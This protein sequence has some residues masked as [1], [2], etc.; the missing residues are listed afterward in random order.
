[1]DKQLSMINFLTYH[2]IDILLVQEHNIRDLNVICKELNELYHILINLSIAHNGGTAIFIDKRLNCYIRNC[3]MSA[4][5][6]I[7]SVNLDFYGKPLHIINVYAPSGGR[8]SDR[9]SFFKDDL[10]YYFRN[11]LD[12]TILG[13]DFNCITSPRDSSSNSTHVCKVLLENLRALYLKDVWFVENRNRPIEYTY[14]RNNYGSRID[15]MYIKNLNN[16]VNNVRVC[17]VNLS[18]HSCVQMSLDLPNVPKVGKFYWKLNASLLDNSEIKDSFKEEWDRLTF[19]INRYD[20]I[21]DWWEFCA[22]KNIKTF[23]INKGKIENQKKYG[24]LKY[25]EYSLNRLYN[26][27]NITNKIDYDRVKS[28]KARIT[29]I[30]TEI[31]EGV[32][33]R[34]RVDEQLKGEI[35]STFLIKK[36]AQIKKKQYLTEIMSEPDIVDN[37]DE[38]IIL[39]NRDSI[40]L[41]I[42]KYYEKLYD[43]EPFDESQQKYFVDLINNKLNEIDRDTLSCEITEAEILNAIK[44][45]NANK[46]PGIDGIPAEF[47]CKFWE[48]IKV[49]LTKIIKNIIH[50][51][52]LGSSQRKAIIT[53]LPKGGDLKFMKSWRPISL[54]CCDVKIVSKILANRIRP[55]MSDIISNNQYCVNGRTIT[56]CNNDLRDVLYYYGETKS[57]GAIINLDWEKAFDRVNW[58]FLIRIMKKM[59]FPESI[60]NWVLVLHT[61]IQSVCMVNGN[62]TMPFDIKRGVRQGCPMSMLFYV[63]FQEPL[64]KAI[65]KCKTIIPP[66]LPSKQVKNLGY[67]DDTSIIVKSDEGFVSA[68]NLLDKFQRASNSKLNLRKTKV[69]GFGE[70]ENRVNWPIK[71][72]KVEMEYFTTLGIT[73]SCRYDVAVDKT[74]QMILNKIKNR[75]PLIRDRYFTLYQKSVIV[76]CLLSSKIWYASHVYPLPL[77]FS[78]LINKELFGYIWKYNY[79]PIKRDVLC[80]PKIN[81]GIGI[82]NVSCKAKS[83]FTATVIKRLVQSNEKDLI[84]YYMALRVN[85]LFGIRALPNRVSHI[86][87]PYYEY[88]IETIRKCY[89]LK[90]FPNLCSRDICSMLYVVTQPEIEKMYP[91]YDWK[92]IWKNVMFKPIHIYDRNIV[93]KY[94]HEILPNRKRLYDMRLKLSPLCDQCGIEESNI[95]LFFY[96]QKVQNCINWMKKLIFYL[97]NIDIGNNLLKCL[98]LDFPKVNRA[99]QNTLCIII[100]SYISCVWYNREEPDFS[101]FRFKA[102]IRKVQKSH[103]LIN[104]DKANFMFTENYCNI[105]SDI[106][107]YL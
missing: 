103:M 80:N 56:D 50:G 83:I 23:F 71:D 60:I 6:R 48:I 16:Y 37:L 78:K 66:S 25:L 28:I 95:N 67:A 76:N 49:E 41:Y 22:K 4:D 55:L 75:I 85:T 105:R 88:S 92:A 30:K 36:Q 44:G 96:C 51:T 79:D 93:F 107:N 24:M 32:K 5:A 62:L 68:F 74:W 11:S 106:L 18:D 39:N 14:I 2:K 17:H 98:F 77:Q 29:N 89:H 86:N 72:L 8:N 1:M 104:K 7:I 21:N 20:S 46:S 43:E 35:V 42:R 82:I 70:W 101:V 26:R 19:M 47:Y 53:L 84:Q 52:L 91:N 31:L 99:I 63:I 59:G 100:C 27:N 10:V 58:K 65:T 61:N 40:E 81:G 97:C 69:Y 94:I 45:L 102:K 13:G 15:R 90:N 3:E 87:T 38:G 64:Y 73:F 12:N 9:D 33:I 54:I 57:T 34:S